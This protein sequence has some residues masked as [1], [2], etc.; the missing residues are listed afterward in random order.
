MPRLVGLIGVVLLSTGVIASGY[1]ATGG[2]GAYL[3]S[4]SAGAVMGIGASFV[5]VASESVLR[6]HFR[7]RL[8]LVLT[9]KNIAASVGFTIVPA[10]THFLLAA[11]GLKTGLLLMT[12]AFIPTALGTLTLRSPPPQRA[13]PYRLSD[14]ETES[15]RRNNG[16]DNVGYD[17]SDK[18]ERNPVPLFSEVNSIYAYQDADE[19]VELFVSPI[20]QASNKWKQELRVIQYFRFWAAVVTW[21]GLR[22]GTL[23]FW[24]LIPVL[25]LERAEIGYQSDDWATLLVIAGVGSFVPSVASRWS[26]TTNAEH[27]KIYF[28]IACWLSG[29]I[30]I[31]LTY[32][33]TYYLFLTCSLIG[34]ACLNS[35]LTCQ[36]L[37][38]CDVLGN[39][40]A[41]YSRRL[42]SSFVGLGMLTFSFV[43]NQNA[44]LTAAALL[45]FVGGFYCVVLTMWNIVQA[46]RRRE[47]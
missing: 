27:R 22:A 38:L 1:L 10:L 11:T 17:S 21:I 20:L 26:I 4:L 31:G 12:V 6:K 2:V 3:A 44:C 34:G 37:A 8:P 32:A 29:G 13:S 15:E 45:L 9:L 18:Q 14:R 33:N 19:D 23:F 47:T 41:Y 28:G 40:F 46:W 7:V 42:F 35:L 43:R 25:F 36:D 16:V 24:I 30:L 5:I 39:Q